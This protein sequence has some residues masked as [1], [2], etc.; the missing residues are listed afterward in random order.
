MTSKV[1]RE[2]WSSSILPQKI[3][4]L[5]RMG[6]RSSNFDRRVA[7]QHAEAT[8][9]FQ[10]G[11]CLL[12][13]DSVEPGALRNRLCEGAGV[14]AGRGPGRTC[15]SR[16]VFQSS[17]VHPLDRD[18]A[19]CNGDAGNVWL[20]WHGSGGGNIVECDIVDAPFPTARADMCNSQTNILLPAGLRQADPLNFP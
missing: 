9:E 15:H 1:S 14:I 12:L 8:L 10:P 13:F 17:T 2:V 4:T 19:I 16:G 3:S 20:G 7:P 11:C 6:D 5:A 18:L